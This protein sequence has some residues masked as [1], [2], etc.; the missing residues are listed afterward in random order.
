MERGANNA[1]GQILLALFLD[2]D[3]QQDE[4]VRPEVGILAHT[5]V[6]A[7]WAPRV[8]EEDERD[9]LA[10]VVQLQAAGAH[11]VHDGRVV[12]DARRDAE[13]TSA[14]EDVGVRRRAKG[15]ADDEEGDILSVRVSQDLVACRLD[16]VAVR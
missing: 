14:E 13:R 6:E 2:F 3:V 16:R 5:V 10:K 4:G 15:V 12:Y 7:V 9:G 8:G 11:R 1:P